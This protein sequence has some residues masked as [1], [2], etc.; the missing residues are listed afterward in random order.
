MA[1]SSANSS[2]GIVLSPVVGTCKLSLIIQISE[3]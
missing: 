2:P 3:K 1:E